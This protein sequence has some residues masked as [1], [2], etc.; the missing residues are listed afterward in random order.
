MITRSKF[1]H[2][3]STVTLPLTLA[4]L[5]ALDVGDNVPGEVLPVGNLFYQYLPSSVLA[6]DDVF[7]VAP[8]TGSGRYVLAPGCIADISVPFTFATP[9]TTIL[10]TANTGFFGV[11][12]RGYWEVATSMTGGATPAIGLSSSNGTGN[13]AQGA[14]IG[15]T[16]TAAL[17][18]GK[19]CGTIGTTIAAGAVLIG[20]NTLRFDA[21][22]SAFTAGA[23]NAHLIVNVLANPGA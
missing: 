16:L 23:G 8:T 3:L 1:G 15:S 21:I 19:R 14:F 22:T 13:T 6:G 18:A 9:D 10:A 11:I 12:Q 2:P 4:Q 20:G 7:V 17:T 5:K